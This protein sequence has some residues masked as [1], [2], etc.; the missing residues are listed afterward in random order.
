MKK[1]LTVALSTAMAFSMFASVAFGDTAVTPQQK[2][3]ALAAKGIFN[4]Y[5]DGSA[6]LEK[7]M[8]RAEFAKVI[9]K[10]LGL[11]E[12]TG[13]LSYKDKGYDAKNWAVPYIEAVTAAG[14]M[15]GQ[16]NVKKI[17]NYN[18][19]VTIQE[20]ATVLTRALKLEIPANPNN[21]AADW[22]K[23]YVQAAIDKGLI[24]KD[25]NFK[26]NASR[27]QLVEAAYAID[28]A[29]NITFTYKVVDPSN[30]EFTLSTGEVVKVK[31]DKPLEANKETEVKFKDAAGNEYTAKV[32]WVS[33]AATK[34]D[35]VTAGSLKQL[36]VKFDGTVDQTTA[37]NVNNYSISNVAFESATLSADKTSVTL[38]I[39]ETSSALSNQK[40]TTLKVNNVKTGDGTK[41]ISQSVNFTPIDVAVPAVT[42]VKGL[43]TK[44]FKVKFSEPV[45]GNTVNASSFRIDGNVIAASVKYVY[46]D[47]AIVTTDLTTGDHTLRVSGVQD[48]SG[49]QIVPTENKFT[50][51][52]DTAAPTVVSVKSNDLKQV[53]V[54]FDETIKSVSSAYANVSSNTATIAK[55]SDNKVTL[56]FSNPLNYT[57][58]TLH[59]AG[60]T[61]YSN[62]SANVDTTVTPTL[63]TVRPTV[64]GSDFYKDGNNYYV[65]LQFSKSLDLESARNKDN[66]V[67]KNADGSVADVTG[68]DSNGHPVIVPSYNESTKKVTVNLGTGLDSSKT[69]SL[70][71]S[72]IKDT[73]YV[74]NVLLPYTVTLAANTVQNG[75]ISRA[76]ADVNNDKKPGYVYLQFN[77]TLSTSGAGSA[78]DAAKYFVKIGD[79][80]Y[81]LTK[82][83]NDIDLISTNT[84][85]IAATNT[86]LPATGW[87][88]ATVKASYVADADG[89]YFS[90]GNFTVSKELNKTSAVTV[91]G[92]VYAT[93]TSKVKVKFD[94]ALS[95]VNI[96]DFFLEGVQDGKSGLPTSYT[97]SDDKK[98]LYLE[99][100][101]GTLAPTVADTVKLKTVA[102]PSTQDSYGNKI[103]A[104]VDGKV[105]KDGIAPSST[106]A[107]FKK[108]GA[109]YTVQINTDEI[110]K[111]TGNVSETFLK[112]M[113]TLNINGADA[114][115]NTVK[116]EGKTVTVTATAKTDALGN[117]DVVTL[118]FDSSKN[119]SVKAITDANDNALTISSYAVQGSQVI[120]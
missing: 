77:K 94:A 53:V 4:G 66:Y 110:V 80:E 90:Q 75:E 11:K 96:G 36:V 111:E 103:D 62:N 113:F 25:A 18:G 41:T 115:I 5:P 82:D 105:V 45:N 100:A 88:G 47:T 13:T 92:D 87:T 59:I 119:S 101:S 118:K 83:S 38:L 51:A 24:S 106:G 22:A 35:S 60:V 85:R 3:D 15:Q 30:V 86:A 70:T 16:D 84:V 46:P 91:S 67:L 69:Y 74:S 108:A 42:E 63:D 7:E 6:H 89:N 9:T 32:T 58:N 28:Q 112:G 8:T 65:E 56:N 71:A 29:T 44:A 102:S 97:L 14:I 57:E 12:V 1:I 27:S 40:Q 52:E 76:W 117:N 78:L 21:N 68:V 26:A 99:F 2:F 39:A 93:S 120:K 20:M 19:K 72:G 23:G 48:F 107:S 95:N 31:L 49:L 37:E 54:E 34:V 104:F 73:A 61:D 79:A 81:Q 114:T 43:G 55:I 64:I 17:F 116:A 10:L 33:T 50:V 109:E 98:T